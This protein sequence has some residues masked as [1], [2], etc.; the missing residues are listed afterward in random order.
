[1][2]NVILSTRDTQ[3][4]DI[5]EREIKKNNDITNIQYQLSYKQKQVKQSV[6]TKQAITNQ[7]AS[8]NISEI[9]K[10]YEFNVIKHQLQF[11]SVEF[12]DF[13]SVIEFASNNKQLTNKRHQI[14]NTAIRAMTLCFEGH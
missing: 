7:R 13:S 1:M 11:V 3:D 12:D 14:K 5:R 2:K 6:K 10:G 8:E 4:V 9:L